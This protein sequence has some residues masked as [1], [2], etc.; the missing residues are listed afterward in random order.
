MMY[1]MIAKL[2]SNVLSSLKFNTHNHIYEMKKV[3]VS[4][5]RTCC[6]FSS[7]EL[8]WNENA[9]EVSFNCELIPLMRLLKIRRVF[10]IENE[11][12]IS[13]WQLQKKFEEEEAFL[14]VMEVATMMIFQTMPIA[15]VSFT[16]GSW[17]DVFFS[18][19]KYCAQLKYTSF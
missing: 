2:Y 13:K 19:E 5:P 18:A 7:A 17:P 15:F 8:T 9:N 6:W 1:F 11:K 3:Y 10:S 4:W 12:Q 14:D 16:F